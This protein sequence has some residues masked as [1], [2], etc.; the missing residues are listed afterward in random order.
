MQERLLPPFLTSALSGLQWLV[1][2]LGG[3]CGF[4]PSFEAIAHSYM[5]LEDVIDSSFCTLTLISI[6]LMVLLSLVC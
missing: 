3:D 5:N 6:R 2:S 4:E 1:Q